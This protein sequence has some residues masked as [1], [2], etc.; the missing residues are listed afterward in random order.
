MGK[1]QEVLSLDHLVRVC[2]ILFKKAA[3]LFLKV[4]VP[5]CMHTSTY[6]TWGAVD[7]LVTSLF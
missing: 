5:F 1:Y 2:L 6:L 3:R 7:C 4:A